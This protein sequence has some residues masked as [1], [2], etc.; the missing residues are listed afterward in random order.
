MQNLVLFGKILGSH[1]A[2][3][4]RN[5]QCSVG[6]FCLGRFPDV[7]A[8]ADNL[9]IV[10]HQFCQFLYFTVVLGDFQ[11]SVEQESFFLHIHILLI[12]C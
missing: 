5:G 3:H 9:V 2:K 11:M 10:L 12:Q 1:L 4:F 8:Q 7:V 6:N